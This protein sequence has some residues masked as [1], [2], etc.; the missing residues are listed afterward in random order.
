MVL[1]LN[2]TLEVFL[3]LSL[4]TTGSLYTNA[5]KTIM[6][7]VS[8][9]S[10]SSSS[11]FMVVRFTQAKSLYSGHT[12]VTA[13]VCKTLLKQC[14]CQS[15]RWGEYVGYI[16]D[17]EKTYVT[18]HFFEFCSWS[19]RKVGN[20]P[21]GLGI[22]WLSEERYLLKYTEIHL[23]RDSTIGWLTSAKGLKTENEDQK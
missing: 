8:Q 23:W 5:W 1:L 4:Q 11:L 12:E 22:K 2:Q 15:R 18:Y 20:R 19:H 9:N 10:F 14:D 17:V 6:L 3:Q 7:S 21:E 16:L 13:W